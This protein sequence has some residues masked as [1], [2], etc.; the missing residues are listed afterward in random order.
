MV[1]KSAFLFLGEDYL[2]KEGKIDIIKKELL[3]GDA[4]FFDLEVLAGKEINERQLSEAL[5][6]LPAVSKDRLIIIKEIDKLNP[7]CKSRLISYLKKPFP[8]TSLVLE[9]DKFDTRDSFLT[10]LTHLCKVI[11]FSRSSPVDVFSLGEAV[12]R[13]KPQES[14]RILSHLLL[15][16]EK[17]QKI[18][19]VLIWQWKKIQPGLSK[20]EFKAGLQMLLDADLNIKR[21]RLKPDFAL[22]L[23]V[24]KL[25]LPV[26]QVL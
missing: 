7:A 2:S 11:N 6:R 9:T 15:S 14:L 4:V 22:E 13:K 25:S 3:K 16:G 23:L 1:E 21:G 8:K 18:L 19:G 17:P 20:S 12:S 10:Q 24:A 26:S 5:K